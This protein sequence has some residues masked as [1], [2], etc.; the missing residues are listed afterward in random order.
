MG[1]Y[2]SNGPIVNFGK[3]YSTSDLDA[4][5]FLEDL[6]GVLLGAGWS[7]NA[8]LAH[9]EFGAL[10]LPQGVIFQPGNFIIWNPA[11]PD[12]PP[13]GFVAVAEAATTALT[14]GNLIGPFA[15]ALGGQPNGITIV[16]GLPTMSI[17]NIPSNNIPVSVFPTGSAGIWS[18]T[19]VGAGN[20]LTWGGGFTWTSRVGDFGTTPAQFSGTKAPA[21]T[22]FLQES[23]SSLVYNNMT[24]GN[25][26]QF[27]ANKY[28]LFIT[29]LASYTVG[30]FF[31]IGHLVPLGGL[32]D[33]N[34]CNGPTVSDGGG[35]RDQGFSSIS[36]TNPVIN[37]VAVD[38]AKMAFQLPATVGG[39]ADLQIIYD[40]ADSRGKLQG[41]LFDAFLAYA[42]QR[43]GGIFWDSILI[44]ITPELDTAASLNG[45]GIDQFTVMLR[46]TSGSQAN[47][48]MLVLRQI[49][50]GGDEPVQID[51]NVVGDTNTA[52]LKGPSSYIFTLNPETGGTGGGVIVSG[53][54]DYAF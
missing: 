8:I 50:G 24:L 47:G 5:N 31:V 52:D 49:Y 3:S 30:T 10:G 40:I 33:F 14:L 2:Y 37:G 16:G 29:C 19:P 28:Q 9:I 13:V 39:I 21:P 48:A 32:T 7:H 43:I 6:D 4:N 11:N 38:Q 34:Y 25:S 1:I 42:P 45:Y 23:A 22:I 54:G 46:S 15:V 18:Y 53:G 51:S 44:S 27:L 41:L 36:D 20:G 17:T 12:P 35:R 26:F